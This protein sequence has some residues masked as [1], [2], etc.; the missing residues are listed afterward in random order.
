MFDL[1]WVFEREFAQFRLCGDKAV[2][3]KTEFHI[4]RYALYFFGS[5]QRNQI[6]CD[7]RQ[8]YVASKRSLPFPRAAVK[9]QAALDPGDDRFHAGPEA[10]QAIVDPLTAAHLFHFQSALLGK[11]HILDP[12]LF[13]GSQVGFGSKPAIQGHLQRVAPINLIEFSPKK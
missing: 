1:I 4:F 13:G 6:G 10:P 7:R 8:P 11:T 3:L 9:S 5:G 2:L 12:A